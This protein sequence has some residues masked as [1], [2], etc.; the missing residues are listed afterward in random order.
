MINFFKPDDFNSFIS[1]YEREL[2]AHSANAKLEKESKTIYSTDG[3]YSDS[4]K[5]R[6]GWQDVEPDGSMP[7]AQYRAIRICTEKIIPCNHPLEKIRANDP[8]PIHGFICLCGAKVKPKE[9]EE[10]K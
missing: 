2:A 8:N 3:Y 1:A 10:V 7:L 5:F 6:N 9:F 4:E